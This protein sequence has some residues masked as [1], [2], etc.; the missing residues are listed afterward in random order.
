MAKYSSATFSV[1]LVD[2]YSLLSAKVQTVSEKV[3]NVV[4]ANTHGLGDR[5]EESSAT[6]LRKATLTQAGAFFNDA[7]AGFH[8][9]FS[10]VTTV[11]R[12]LVYAMAG[13]VIGQAFTGLQGVYEGAYSVIA[14]MAGLTMADAEYVVAGQIDRGVIVQDWVAKTANWNTKTDGASVDH[15]LSPTNQAI[16]ITSNSIAAATVVTTPVPHKLTT[17]DVIVVSGVVTSTPTIN[18]SQTVTVLSPTTFSVP[19]TVTVA[20]TGG[21]F[22]RAS[23]NNGGVGYLLVSALTGFTAVAVNIRHSADDTT[24]ADLVTFAPVTAP[25]PDA[26]AAQRVTVAGVIGRYLSVSGT[27]TG[28]GSIT[29]FAGF[30][31]NAPQ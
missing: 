31:R 5:W 23:S 19:I 22:V 6:G 15:T 4:Q 14:K 29:P 8:E 13:N 25:P 24:Y 7:V 17:G 9:A 1:F 28:A 11:S 21:S 12:L 30:K 16:P 27:V 18:G 3:T 10:A 26:S 2:G 20:G